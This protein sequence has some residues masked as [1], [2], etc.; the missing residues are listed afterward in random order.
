M[1]VPKFQVKTKG[2][3]KGW[4]RQF[5]R[6]TKRI[7]SYFEH[8]DALHSQQGSSSTL[9]SCNPVKEETPLIKSIPMVDQ[10]P[11]E[12]HPYIIDV[13]DVV[14][15]GHCGYRVVAALLVMGEES[16]VVV[17]MNLLK[18]LSHFRIEYV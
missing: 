7:P 4:A 9:K 10:F 3:K 16:W 5:A 18:E 8:V 6:S 17:R 13:V 2:A 15:D 14:A 11:I 12:I 1:G